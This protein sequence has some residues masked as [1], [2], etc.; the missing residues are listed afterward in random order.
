MEITTVTTDFP[1]NVDQIDLNGK[2]IYIVGT[3]HVSQSSVE[4]VEE[5]IRKVRPDTVAVELCASRYQS[6]KDPDRWRNTD[7]V[8]L[9]KSGRAYVLMAQ[10]VLA[11]FQKKL[12]AQFNIKP[13]AEM[14]RSLAVAEELDC[15][16]VLADRDVRTTLKRTWS[17]IG[18]FSGFKLIMALIISMVTNQKVSEEEIEALK[19]KDT[20]SNLMHEFSAKFPSLRKTLIDERDLY[21]ASK[22]GSAPGSSVVAVVGAGHVPGIKAILGREIDVAAL[23]ALPSRGVIGKLI[24]WSIPLAVVGLVIYGF[25]AAGSGL[26]LQM[27]GA[28]FW[29]TGLFGAIGSTLALAHPVTIV[30]AFLATPFATLHPLIAAGWIAGLVEAWLKKPR[31]SDFECVLQDLGS[32]KG[33]WTNRVTRI[34]LIIA[35][36][37]LLAT[38]GMIWG[39][40]VIAE[41]AL[42]G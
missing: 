34:L 23:E 12:G 30:S 9:I 27:L 22:I 20:L 40:K 19:S 31:V 5:V 2:R 35:L 1:E 7:I 21:L 11:S 39:A 4:L 32:L 15:G 10:L 6:L 18:F 41:L 3:A 8:A 37:N 14:L 29:I 42:I 25:F 24:G 26:S 16:T 38:I 36:T 33:I 13:G 17:E 28:W